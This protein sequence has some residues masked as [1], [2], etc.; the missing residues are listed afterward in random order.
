M[1]QPEPAVTITL[2]DR[3]LKSPAARRLY[4]L[5]GKLEAKRLPVGDFLPSSRVGVERKTSAD[6]EDSIIDGRLFSQAAEL[7]NN[8]ERPFVGVIGR[9]F[10]RLQPSAIRGALISL[11]V[12]YR[13][14]VVFFDSEEEFAEFLFAL[15]A[16]EQGKGREA[17]LRFEKKTFTLA[18][19]QQ[20]IVESL[21]LIGPATAKHLL[22]HF[23]TVEN[24]FTADEDE[25]QA[26][27][28]VGGERA[29]RI[30]HL[31]LEPYRKGNTR[32]AVK[33]GG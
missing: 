10:S 32:Q 26:V 2:D 8:F 16:R 24:V 27:E 28:G 19:Q 23:Q 29:R 1:P 9:E 14:P 11:L 25:L 31:L 20:F 33:K 5:G 18:E 21:P 22:E 30:R 6:F 15:A 7:T 4:Q 13:L 3:E 12:D 17:R